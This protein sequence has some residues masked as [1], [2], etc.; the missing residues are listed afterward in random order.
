MVMELVTVGEDRG[1]GMVRRF[2][3]LQT[4]SILNGNDD[5]NV[6]L[7]ILNSEIVLQSPLLR[8]IFPTRDP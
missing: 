6:R 4:G 1:F 8:E 7:Q 3:T 2:A 5:S